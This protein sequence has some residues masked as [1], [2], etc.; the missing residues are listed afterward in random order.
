MKLIT[1]KLSILTGTE[2][3][4]LVMTSLNEL[5]DT[6]LPEL[7][8]FG[9]DRTSVVDVAMPYPPP[10]DNMDAWQEECNRIVQAA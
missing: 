10:D 3:V 1:I 7:D 8:T 4:E 9:F 6:W 2:D 5:L